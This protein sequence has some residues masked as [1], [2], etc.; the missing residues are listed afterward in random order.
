MKGKKRLSASVDAEL[1]RAAEAAAK[2]GVASTVSA[3]VN[4]ALRLKVEHD[5][6]QQ[7]LSAFIDAYED[8]HG[9]ITPEEIEGAQRAARG[10]AVP[11]RTL[12]RGRPVRPRRGR[13]A[14]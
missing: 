6:R 13:G 3:W 14:A 1:L 12:A 8:Q 5:R 9:V 7:A 4:D 10:R 2:R 11:V